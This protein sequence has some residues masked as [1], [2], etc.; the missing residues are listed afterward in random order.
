MTIGPLVLFVALG[1]CRGKDA[2]EAPQGKD[3]GEATADIASDK[4]VLASAHAAASEVVR[5][6]GDCAVVK[7]AAPGVESS[8]NEL[9]G[10]V[11]TAAGKAT[12]EALRKQVRDIAEACP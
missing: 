11:R 10:G 8:L 6:A 4:D 5:A 9:E 7:A 2:A 12:F 3:L 1:G